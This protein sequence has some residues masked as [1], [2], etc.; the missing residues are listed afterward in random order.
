MA[1]FIFPS[2][3]LWG[4]ATAS[5]QVEGA[6]FEDGKGES[7]WDRFSHTP[8]RIKH[9][10]IG[11]VACDHYHR[12]LEDVAI[13]Q[14][15]GLQAYRFSISWPRILPQ[16]DGAVNEAGLDFYDRLVD[17]LLAAHIEP[18]ATLYH[19]DLPQALQDRQGGWASRHIAEQFAH[20]AD[21]VSRRLGDRVKRWATLNEPHVVAVVGYQHG[22]HA[23]GVADPVVAAQVSHHLLLAH[24]M[25]VPVLRANVG[26]KAQIGIVNNQGLIENRPGA[27]EEEQAQRDFADAFVNRLFMDTIFHGVYPEELKNAPGFAEIVMEPGDFEIMCAPLDFVGVNYYTRHVVGQSRIP[28]AEYTTMDWEVYPEGLYRVLTRIHR[29]YA[30]KAIYVTESGAA[31]GDVVSADGRV[32]DARRVSYLREHFRMAAKAIQD[33]VPLRGY[34]VWSLLD[35][36]EWAYGYTQ[37]FGIVRVEYETGQ[38]IL[39]DSAYFYQSVIRANSA[40]I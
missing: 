33:G 16:G 29:D 38:R 28:N 13:M 7:I 31:F 30:P 9:G 15:I 26:P 22:H 20:Y 39:K 6:A 1:D 21:V 4:A 10:D 37:R 12:Y 18:L 2:D 19:W 23:P 3:F 27:S 36:F 40:E 35:N 8:G 34:F 14:T 32:H 25:A 17:A 11:D 5:Y 24:G